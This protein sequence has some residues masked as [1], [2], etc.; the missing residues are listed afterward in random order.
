MKL[1]T[2]WVVS[3]G[4]ILAAT[5]AN[6]QSP[7]PVETGSPA[8]T[9]VSDIDGPYAAMPPEAPVPPVAPAPRG[10][11]ML[12]PSIEV[13]TVLRD[14]GFL[15]TGIP[16][17]H[18]LVYTISVIDR[19]GGDGRLVIDARNGRIIRYVPAY[20]M[21]GNFYGPA[22]ALPPWTRVAGAPRPPASIPHVASRTVPV[23]KPNPLAGKPAPA[24]EPAQQSAAVQPKPADTQAAAPPPAAPTVGQ[25][26][27]AEPAAPAIQPTQEMPKVQGLE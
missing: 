11:P 22:G 13:Y 16:R 24:P 6:A 23:P 19:G 25:A 8:S 3:V 4:L 2:G 21:G 12:L 18:G 17:Q 9:P 20:R 7:A 5:S 14:N 15:P 1:F 10:G 27:A 26:K